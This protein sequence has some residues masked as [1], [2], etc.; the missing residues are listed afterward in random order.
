MNYNKYS[1]KLLR[2]GHLMKSASPWLAAVSNVMEFPQF[3]SKHEDPASYF[4]DL[5]ERLSNLP[6]STPVWPSFTDWPKPNAHFW[7]K[8]G[9]N[10]HSPRTPFLLS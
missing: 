1:R 10:K 4:A 2:V 3:P 8:G 9:P 6:S 5:G 7:G